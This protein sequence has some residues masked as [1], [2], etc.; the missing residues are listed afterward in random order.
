MAGI[1]RFPFSSDFGCVRPMW[2]S[3]MDSREVG[4][5]ACCA[6]FRGSCDLSSIPVKTATLTRQSYLLR[7]LP[8]GPAYHSILF[9]QH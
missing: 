1:N 6:C 5:R 9:L 3:S 7:S 2:S 4:E 8:V